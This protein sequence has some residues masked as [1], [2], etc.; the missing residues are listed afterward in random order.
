MAAPTPAFASISRRLSDCEA[1]PVMG[2]AESFEDRPRETDRGGLDDDGG[3]R[4]SDSVSMSVGSDHDMTSAWPLVRQDCA[5]VCGLGVVPATL[6][7]PIYP[8]AERGRDEA[9][10]L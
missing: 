2:F 4:S 1:P 6:P 7:T 8:S 10:I 9:Y 3:G 5:R